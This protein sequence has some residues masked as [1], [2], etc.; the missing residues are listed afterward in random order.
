MSEQTDRQLVLGH[1]PQRDEES[2][3]H[4]TTVVSADLAEQLTD[5]LSAAALTANCVHTPVPD[6]AR[7]RP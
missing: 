4:D 5:A 6:L 2:L 3:E 1:A 7:L